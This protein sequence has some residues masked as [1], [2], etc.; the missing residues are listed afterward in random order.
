LDKRRKRQRL[1][2]KTLH[3]KLEERYRK[4][5][6]KSC[7]SEVY[8]EIRVLRYSYAGKKYFIDD[9]SVF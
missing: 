5:A 3:N 9:V 4:N 7:T 1:I 8:E 2:H 6:V